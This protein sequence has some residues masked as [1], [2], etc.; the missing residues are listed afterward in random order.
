VL[1]LELGQLESRL[2]QRGAESE[3]SSEAAFCAEGRGATPGG[4]G[5]FIVVGKSSHVP[6]GGDRGGFL[7]SAAHFRHQEANVSRAASLVPQLPDAAIAP[8]S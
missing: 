4:G 6:S 8:E 1:G 2:G 5:R 7:A 3:V